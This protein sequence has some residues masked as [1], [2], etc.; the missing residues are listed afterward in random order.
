M[1]RGVLSRSF[2][3]ACHD[4]AD[5]ALRFFGCTTLGQVPLDRKSMGGAIVCST[6]SHWF[7]AT[8]GDLLIIGQRLILPVPLLGRAFFFLPSFQFTCRI[9]SMPTSNVKIANTD[10][11]LQVLGYIYLVMG[12]LG[13]IGSAVVGYLF[14][15]SGP[16]TYA[17]E[18]QEML[19]IAG[20]GTIILGILV[21]ASIASVITGIGL[22]RSSPWS[23]TF[24][25]ILSIIG[26]IDFPL[27]TVLGIYAIWVLTRPGGEMIQKPEIVRT[28][29]N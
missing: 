10:L 11:H 14:Y 2:A 15:G 26:L 22:I 5:S 13:C 1:N 18:T 7:M 6:I 3:G 28:K 17:P 4:A 12:I 9:F 21:F 16:Y 20:Y 25:W 29:K 8:V 23:K 19:I 24:L 27:G